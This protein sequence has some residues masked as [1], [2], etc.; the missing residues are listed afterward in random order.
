MSD[1]YSEQVKRGMLLSGREDAAKL[2]ETAGT[3][4]KAVG[5][6]IDASTGAGGIWSGVK[7]FFA[8]GPGGA[9]AANIS[10]GLAKAT[11]DA[12]A[13]TQ[14][15]TDYSK[16]NTQAQT[17]LQSAQQMRA[18]QDAVSQI[19]DFSSQAAFDQQKGLTYSTRGLGIGG[20]G[21]K[22]N[23][24]DP[25]SFTGSGMLGIDSTGL[26]PGAAG[27]GPRLQGGGAAY[28]GDIKSY[29]KGKEGLALEAYADTS[30][31]YS[32]GYG[33]FVPG[34]AQ[35]GQKID[36]KQ[37]D[38]LFEKDFSKHSGA[39]NEMLGEDVM[40]KLNAGQK[41]ALYD[42]AYNAGPGS[43]KYGR[44]GQSIYSRLKRGDIDGAGEKLLTTATTAD[45][46]THPGLV[47]RR[48]D[49]YAMWTGG[50]SMP[51]NLPSSTQAGS[52][53]S[54]N[55][56]GG[57]DRQNVQAMLSNPEVIKMI[58]AQAGLSGKDVNKLVGM[59]VG[60]LGKEF[61]R[62]G[63]I[64]AV[65][66]ITRAGQLSRIGYTQSPEQYFQA[67]SQMTGVGGGSEDFEE[68][69]KNAVAN[70]MDS[71]KNIMEMVNATSQLAG[72][73][74]TAGI[75]AFGGAAEGL[76]RGIDAL[77]QTGVSENMATASAARAAGVAEDV[78]GS[79]D[80]D[81][82]NVIETAR[83]RKDFG[84]ANLQQLE[85]LRTA[86]PQE[87]AQLQKLYKGGKK[88]EAEEMT[89]K[90]GLKGVLNNAD[91]VAKAQQATREQVTRRATGFGINREMEESIQAAQ[92]EGRPLTADQ[93]SFVNGMTRSNLG[94]DVSGDALVGY[95]G[96]NDARKGG[97]ATDPGG[98]VRSG[99][100]TIRSGAVADAKVF[101]DGVKNI[102]GAMGGLEALG[103]SMM[104]VA[105]GIKPD[106]FAKS[107]KDAAQDFKIPANALGTNVK[108]L[109][110]A[111][112][113]LI[114]TLKGVTTG[115]GID[116]NGQVNMNQLRK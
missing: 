77:R 12:L 5:T 7:G 116:L 13:F 53:V 79:K 107:V 98:G 6:A 35:K 86:S 18:L 38:E 65:N 27:A 39:V 73:S 89:V 80:L 62:E 70:G 57:G 36:K 10:E 75:A 95:V 64:G 28:T 111:V 59:G 21:T 61:S 96:K 113:D 46:Q 87:L 16:Q 108:E 78:S 81:I 56:A 30:R 44:K 102:T 1:Q 15:V 4:A 58:A 88:E 33:S 109:T 63:G 114:K 112:G 20:G 68:I 48:Q 47:G 94:R 17:F 52:L 50:G 55:I 23:Y 31:G 11:P 93:R 72:R 26:L 91:D 101:E 49:E 115:K 83:L 92:R 100:D 54:Q 90:M 34:T 97:L 104:K 66:D 45:G 25:T 32:I 24:Y 69:L 8:G 85:S 60:G 41:N 14:N 22:S 99:E 82:A 51:A 84:K 3:G 110:T 19:S 74:A 2:I 37:A 103:A 40:G 9:A 29:I 71:S 43:L 42:L 76:G 67:R 105:E 106:E